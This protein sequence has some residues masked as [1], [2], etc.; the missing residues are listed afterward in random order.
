MSP[1]WLGDKRIS[2]ASPSSIDRGTVDLNKGEMSFQMFEFQD[3]A[4]LDE[5]VTTDPISIKTLRTLASKIN[6]AMPAFLIKYLNASLKAKPN[7]LAIHA[8]SSI[9]G[10]RTSADQTKIS[11]TKGFIGNPQLELGKFP[12]AIH[13]IKIFHNGKGKA[14]VFYKN[15]G[16]VSFVQNLKS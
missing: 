15:Q 1:V 3:M 6:E 14:R 11:R 12:N 2:I 13:H 9:E 4:E 10:Y 5:I 16:R 7:A 8:S